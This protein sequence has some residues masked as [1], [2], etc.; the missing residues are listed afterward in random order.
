M[1]SDFWACLEMLGRILWVCAYY[2]LDMEIPFWLEQGRY[3]EQMCFQFIPQEHWTSRRYRK[4][5]CLQLIPGECHLLVEKKVV[6][7]YI[8]MP[9]TLPRT[10]VSLLTRIARLV[11]L[12]IWT[13]SVQIKEVM[14]QGEKE[15]F[16][17]LR[18]KELKM[19]NKP[20]SVY[21]WFL[22]SSHH[23]YN[24]KRYFW[25]S[26]Q[27]SLSVTR[28]HLVLRNVL[29]AKIKSQDDILWCLQHKLNCL[30]EI[31]MHKVS[32]TGST[33]MPNILDCWTGDTGYQ[34]Y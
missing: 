31:L 7:K 18:K 1:P 4:Q 8:Q 20:Q 3:R 32:R 10:W 21:L 19:W 16:Q 22:Q 25:K 2:Q 17:V 34:E 24:G 23:Q 15:L 11:G 14:S 33:P 27:P 5:P 6:S 26:I 28:E 12:C 30:S 9:E 29:V 13:L